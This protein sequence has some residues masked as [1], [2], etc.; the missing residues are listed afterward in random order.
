MRM[1]YYLA[2]LYNLKFNLI[3]PV[4]YHYLIFFVIGGLVVTLD[5]EIRLGDI[6]KNGRRARPLINS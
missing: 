1:S 4:Y 2:A 3:I 5:S 6:Q